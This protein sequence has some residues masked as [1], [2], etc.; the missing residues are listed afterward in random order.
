L[1]VPVTGTQSLFFDETLGIN[2][3]DEAGIR[4][5]NDAILR[6]YPLCASSVMKRRYSGPY[7]PD[8]AGQT[9]LD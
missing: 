2:R 5:Q 8:Q 1:A 7:I 3:E 4:H 6:N 9:G